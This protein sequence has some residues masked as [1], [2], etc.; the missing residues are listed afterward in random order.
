M[1]NKILNYCCLVL[2]LFI[3]SFQIQS[4]KQ[5][6]D[7]DIQTAIGSETQTN[8]NLAGVSA[9][10]VNG[11]VTLTGQCPDEDCRKNAEKAIKKIDGVK[12]V[13]NNIIVEASVDITPDK[14]LKEMTDKIVSK[15]KGVEAGVS[16]GIITL[17]GEIKKDKLQQLMID[18][19]SLRPKRIDNQL[20]VR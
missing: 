5:N 1:K 15:Y 20:A 13:T 4:C 11:V 2:L 3:L 14:D 9:T 7:A 10:V 17:R 18:L 12:H 8:P 19:N 6:R 16:N